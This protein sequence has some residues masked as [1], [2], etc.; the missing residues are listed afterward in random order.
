M[1]RRYPPALVIEDL[2]VFAPYF[3]TKNDLIDHCV[4]SRTTAFK[5]MRE[6]PDLH[7]TILKVLGTKIG[8]K[9]PISTATIKHASS[10]VDKIPLK[11]KKLADA[12]EVRTKRKYTKRKQAAEEVITEEVH[13]E[14][15]T[16]AIHVPY[17]GT[18][19]KGAYITRE[20][21]TEEKL[22]LGTQICELISFG[23]TIEEACHI[24]DIQAINFFRWRQ[25]IPEL[26]ERYKTAVDAFYTQHHE[27]F[28]MLAHK[29]LHRHL[30]EREVVLTTKVGRANKQG[31][32]KVTS[33]RSQTKVI[34]PSLVA[35]V[36]VLS[37]M[38]SNKF[39][40]E[41]ERSFDRNSDNDNVDYSLRP[42][43]IEDLE[44]ELALLNGADLKGDESL[45]EEEEEE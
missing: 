36:K 2:M 1:S 30:T 28:V 18:S 39:G 29:G 6:D 9:L 17:S 13:D 26:E 12:T 45:E 32:V 34:E 43:S 35:I 31:V 42:K 22:A 24:K 41:K 21:T 4:G 14:G 10:I 5:V 40:S 11:T 20:A 37:T 19:S 25:S 44:N 27:N 38:E 7:S 3:K 23:E 33:V 8:G 16:D 15:P